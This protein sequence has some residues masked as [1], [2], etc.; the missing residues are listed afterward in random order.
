VF[1]AAVYADDVEHGKPHPEALLRALE[2]LGVAPAATVYVGDTTV[3][4]EMASAAG[5]RFAAVG[6]T[7]SADDFRAAGVTR[8]WAGVG[9]WADDLLG[10]Q[11]GGAAIR[12]G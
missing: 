1:D 9:A 10:V 11:P 7:T 5:A 3:D 12:H 8:V 6:T 2:E 4:L